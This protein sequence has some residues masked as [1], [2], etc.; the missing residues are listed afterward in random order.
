M[1]RAVP[2]RGATPRRPAPGRAKAEK[3]EPAILNAARKLCFAHGPDG[4]T[5]RRIAAEVGCS[6]TAIY[7]YY[8]SVDHVL[9]RLRLEGHALLSEY[10]RR[11]PASLG[12]T[13]AQPNQ[14]MC[15]ERG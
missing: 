3:L 4:V 8:D 12:G 6:A 2:K 9:H 11:P 1:L 14:W 10:L 13:N 7:L 5:A 15:V